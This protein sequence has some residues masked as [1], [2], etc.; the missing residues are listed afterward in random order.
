[1]EKKATGTLVDLMLFRNEI[2]RNK[3]LYSFLSGS[4]SLDVSYGLLFESSLKTAG[5]LQNKYKMGDRVI[6]ALKPGLDFVSSF[7]GCLCA[8]IIPI[9]LYPPFSKAFIDKITHVIEDASPKG[10]ITSQDLAEAGRNIGWSYDNIDLILYEEFSDDWAVRWKKPDMTGSDIAFI[11]YTSG[12]TNNPKGVVVTHDNIIH[13]EILINKGFGFSEGENVTGVSWL[14]LYHDLGLIGVVLQAFYAGYKAVLMSP[15]DFLAD[16]ISWLETISKTRAVISGGPNFAY[17]LCVRKYDAKRCEKLDLSCWNIAFSGAEPVRIDTID[18]FCSLYESH[19]FKRNSFTPCYGLAENTLFASCAPKDHRFNEVHVDKDAFANGIITTAA[20]AS[21]TTTRLICNGVTPKGQTLCIVDP[22]RLEILPENRVGEIW[23]KGESVAK[24]YWN[25]PDLTRETFEAYSQEGEGPFLRTGD[26]GFLMNGELYIAGRI[27]DMMIFRGRNYYPQDIEMSVEK[28][29]SAIRSGRVAAFMTEDELCIIAE[30]S[31]AVERETTHNIVKKIFMQVKKDHELNSGEVILVSPKSLPVTTSGKIRRNESRARFEKN[32]FSVI[33]RL[34]KIDEKIPTHSEERIDREDLRYSLISKFSAFFNLYPDEIDPDQPFGNYGMTS[35]EAVELTDELE[36][37]TNKPCSPTLFYDYPTVNKLIEFFTGHGGNKEIENGASLE[38]H[39]DYNGDIAIIGVS[40]RFPGADGIDE[41]WANL[42]NSIDS[43]VEFP[44]DVRSSFLRNVKGNF[45][46]CGGFI[47]DIDAFDANFFNINAREARLMDP[48]HRLFLETVWNTIENAGYAPKKLAGMDIGVFA[49]VSSFDYYEVIRESGLEPEAYTATGLAH[50]M[51]ANRISYL[52]DFHGPS[53]AIDTACSSSLVAV[54]R[55]ISA[56]RQGDCSMAVAGGVNIMISG[57]SFTSL[58]RSGF[59]S[60]QG[61]CNTFDSHADGYVRGEGVGAVLLKPLADAERDGDFIHAVIKGAAVCH[62]GKTESL[63]APGSSAQSNLVMKSVHNSK[64][65]PGSI[66]Y[67]ET[68]GTGTILGD[69]I[70]VNGLLMA[71]RE[72]YRE[73]GCDYKKPSCALGSVKS[74]IG[75]LE[76]AAGIAGLIKVME[77]LKRKTIP[78]TAHLRDIN[79]LIQIQETPF[80]INTKNTGWDSPE[81]VDGHE[82]PRRAGISS[83]GFGGSYAHVVL[84]EYDCKL[85][86]IK[87][88][89]NLVVYS[90]KTREGLVRLVIRQLDWLKNKSHAWMTEGG[91]FDYAC[92][93]S[94]GRDHHEHRLAVVVADKN[95]LIDCLDEYILKGTATRDAFLGSIEKV[96]K[97][98]KLSINDLRTAGAQWVKGRRFDF[99]VLRQGQSFRK[100]PLPG[101]SF[102]KTSYFAID[103]DA[104]SNSAYQNFHAVHSDYSDNKCTKIQRSYEDIEMFLRDGVSDIT[105][106]DKSDLA[107]DQTFD[108]W[109]M[110]SIAVISL[111]SRLEE[112]AG[113]EIPPSAIQDHRTIEHLARFVAEGAVVSEKIVDLIPETELDEFQ[114]RKDTPMAPVSGKAIF[115]TGCTGYLGSYLLVELLSKTDADIYCLVRA[116]NKE[117]GK[118]RIFKA[119]RIFGASDN[120]N[121]YTHRIH[122]VV[123][124]LGEWRLGLERKEFN[125]LCTVIDTIWHCGATVDWM[126]PYDALKNTNV[127]GTRE[128]IKMAGTVQIKTLHFISSLAVL[129]LVNGENQWFEQ[130]V[131]DPRGITVGYGQSKWVAEQLCLKASRWN[132]PVYVYRFDYVAGTPGKGVMKESDFIARL[133]KGSI[134]LGVIPLEETNFDIIPVD[135]LCRMMTA[136]AQ[137]GDN[138]GKIYHLINRRPFSTSDFA[139]LIRTRGYKVRRMPFEFWKKLTKKNPRNALYPLYPFIN[140]YDTWA[141]Q[142]YSSWTVDNTNTMTALFKADKTLISNIP[143]P[144]DILESVMD[145]LE[146]TGFIPRGMFGH[147]A[148]RQLTYWENQLKDVPVGPAVPVKS[149]EFSNANC[150]DYYGTVTFSTKALSALRKTGLADG[151]CDK[152]IM[153]SLVFVL[154]YRYGRQSDIL[155][156][157]SDRSEEKD[158][159]IN[160]SLFIRSVVDS[161]STISSMVHT[162]KQLVAEAKANGDI[163]EDILETMIGITDDSYPAQFVWDVDGQ[164]QYLRKSQIRFMFSKTGEGLNCRIVF[165]SARY[166]KTIIEKMAVH[167]ENLINRLPEH[168]D[169]S[170]SSFSMLSGDERDELIFKHNQTDMDYP[171]DMCI[172]SLFTKK[173]LENPEKIALLFDGRNMSYGELNHRSDLVAVYLKLRGIGRGHVVGIH[174]DRSMTMIVALMGILKCGAAYLPLDKDYPD[175]R[176]KHMM[177]DAQAKL[178]F[179]DQGQEKEFC[180]DVPVMTIENES[181][182]LEDLA[183][184]KDFQELLAEMEREAS[185]QDVAYMIYTSGSTGKPKGVMAMHQGIVNLVHAMD[186]LV[187]FGSDDT[188]LCLTRL[189]FDMVKPELYIPLLK[190]G[191]M[192]I[193]PEHVGKDGYLL[194]EFLEKNSISL[195]QAT[196]SSWR[197]LTYAGWQGNPRMTMITGGEPLPG[198]LAASLVTK[199]KKLLNL[200]GPTET[201]V[202][203]TAAHITENSGVHIGYPIGNTKLYVLDQDLQPV[204]RGI[205]GELY[206]AGDGVTKGYHENSELTRSRYLVDPFHGSGLS[207]MYRTGDLVRMRPDGA[208]EYIERIDHQVKVRGYRIELKEIE[209]TLSSIPGVEEAVV[210]ARDNQKGDK[211]LMAWVTGDTRIQS[212]DFRILKEQIGEQLPPWMVPS[213]II[214]LESMPLNTNGKIDRSRLPDFKADNKDIKETPQNYMEKALVFMWEDVLGIPNIGID[215]DFIEWGGDSLKAMKL[216]VDVNEQFSVS[217]TV[218]RLFENMTV[219]KLADTLER[220]QRGEG[221]HENDT[222]A[223]MREDSVLNYDFIN[224]SPEKPERYGSYSHVFLTGVTGY[225]GAYL[226]RDLLEKTDASVFCLVRAKNDDGAMIR[227]KT[228]LDL[229]GLWDD[230]YSERIIPLSG[231]LALPC[232]GLH[233]ETYRSVSSKADAVFHNGAMV[234]FSYPYALLKK[235]NV[236]GTREVL[237]FA[238]ENRI[239]PLYYVS[240]IGVFERKNPDLNRPVFE[241]SNLPNPEELYYGY[242]QSKWVAEKLVRAYRDFGMP[243]TIVRPGPIYGDSQSGAL[244]TDDFF[245]RM[246]GACS[247]FNAVPELNVELDGLPVDHVSSAIVDIALT[248]ETMGRNYHIVSPYPIHLRTIFERMNQEGYTMNMISVPE[249]TDILRR[250][251]L[252]DPE[253]MAFLPLVDAVMPDTGGK[254]FFQMQTGNRQRYACSNLMDCLSLKGVSVE[255][256]QSEIFVRYLEFMRMNGYIQNVTEEM[257]S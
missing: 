237:K 125:F 235:A 205:A 231:D 236:T 53:E 70:E 148:G 232:F 24:G 21:E 47:R 174:M 199:G 217:L 65:H 7:F 16:P 141:F 71:F 208:L 130:P 159:Q 110:D 244:N 223:R 139:E 79:P 54:Y 4:E 98:D 48:Q 15:L 116:E 114:F 166:D 85:T 218:Q 81:T 168:M 192:H 137:S 83:F 72:L 63:T 219:R 8:G 60:A 234:N 245:C 57:G 55:A 49:G 251:A 256:V 238:S 106:L 193:L 173:A 112:W 206:I 2:S 209:Q 77:I 253:L 131:N 127:E 250:E 86:G 5:F 75:H 195:M 128:I 30:Y 78:P 58:G 134:Q 183:K 197:L 249:W 105:G 14:P 178:V 36:K 140:R 143:G 147:I 207:R 145:Y 102:E 31:G 12:S 222:A 185:P 43:V 113:L 243:V 9:P 38:R 84:E 100:I 213:Q 163:A 175:E 181:K 179:I 198:N 18:R 180:C 210:L 142:S 41:F 176:L 214:I 196:P 233:E 120:F 149:Y 123:G 204:P 23:I 10:I 150:Q 96:I 108:F 215:D 229:Y 64:I 94:E 103:H 247:K 252:D 129:P 3:E 221:I 220:M 46:R 177:N 157:A 62:G 52:M 119:A 33:D 165:D 27:K 99:A 186:K 254:T 224:G 138:H 76:S 161:V 34:S 29:S 121:Q 188:M 95:A 40:C 228:N 190:G 117:K 216:L 50:T 91:L 19:G 90:S 152:D 67:I 124:D 136:I 68:H 162:M 20:I 156:A 92:T 61:H 201:T 246:I 164:N 56:L 93:L 212:M 74:N 25:K 167:L 153:L 182:T 194:K 101:Y 39:R 32:E 132:I 22:E 87:S 111:I 109:G 1:M 51:I 135:Y 115:L 97:D 26:L 242:A 88:A 151:L 189:S 203:S 225:L 133:I 240:T 171:K 202:W 230:G 13:N 80:Y 226:L 200:Y 155:I 255:P 82:L 35:S 248:P 59:L 170:L 28:T 172:H 73:N 6:L 169:K 187:E 146:N 11:Q 118:E 126:K 257:E 89:E 241:D 122:T 239:K 154:L 44:E 104:S 45:A 227:I 66:G 17:D 191:T 158:V 42:E 107:S 211:T 69:P 144:S 160:P 184:R 37:I